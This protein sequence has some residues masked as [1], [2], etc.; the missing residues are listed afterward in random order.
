MEFK[1]AIFVKYLRSLYKVNL[2]KTNRIHKIL[3]EAI[4]NVFVQMESDINQMAL[5]LS[6]TTATGEWLDL[7][8][9]YFDIG[10]KPNEPDE[11][12]SKR[13]IAEV[14]EPK[15]TLNALRKSITR[16]INL[17]YDEEYQESEIEVY[18]PWKDLLVTSHR[19]SISYLGRLPD[20]EYW[21]HGVVDIAIPDSSEMSADL[22]AYLNTI[23]ACGVKI[24]WHITMSWHVLTGYF[25]SDSVEI[26]ID[27]Y[28]DIWF[29]REN[30]VVNGFRISG[31]ENREEYYTPISVAGKLSG[32]QENYFELVRETELDAFRFTT[33]VIQCS[34]L[35][36]LGDISYF[37]EVSFEELTIQQVVDTELTADRQIPNLDNTGLLFEHEL[38]KYL[39]RNVY[40]LQKELSPMNISELTEY[41][42]TTVLEDLCEKYDEVDSSGLTQFIKNWRT[43]NYLNKP[44]NTNPLSHCT[45]PLKIL[46]ESDTS[47]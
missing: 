13:M 18:E 40:E 10:R 31:G 16:W 21:T 45:G 46:I 24:S 32:I 2:D 30:G 29:K 37:N 1:S 4:F 41:F 38:M 28:Y 27:K 12:Y 15:A 43:H 25:E 22:I 42:N 47:I 39:S 8:G 20:S 3:I 23:K 36:T 34:P 19:G 33:R 6:I 44:I 35:I 5:E 14:I 7:W 17:N 9:E 26:F 11:K